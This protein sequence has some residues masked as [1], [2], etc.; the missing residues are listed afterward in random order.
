MVV[1]ARCGYMKARWC[2]GGLAEEAGWGRSHNTQ[3]SRGV[4]PPPPPN[5]LD[6]R[7]WAPK[8]RRSSGGLLVVQT[9]DGTCSL[10]I[11]DKPESLAPLSLGAWEAVSSTTPQFF[12]ER[13]F[14]IDLGQ[15]SHAPP[16]PPAL[17]SE[18]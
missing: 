17:A 1:D 13:R 14:G 18:R 4:A 16:P 15:L 11:A 8:G 12:A 3:G 5:V 9:Q 7:R 10:P 2:S 6:D